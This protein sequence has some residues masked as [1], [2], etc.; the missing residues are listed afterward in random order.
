MNNNPNREQCMPL[1]S[2]MPLWLLDL[3]LKTESSSSDSNP[4]PGSLPKSQL[5]TIQDTKIVGEGITPRAWKISEKF[6]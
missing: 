2:K 5:I 3:L 1:L 4:G 6:E